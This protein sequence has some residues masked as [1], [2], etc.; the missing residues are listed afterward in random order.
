MA[1]RPKTRQRA[2]GELAN[3]IAKAIHI[4]AY[5]PGEWLRQIDLEEA[6]QATR[7][8]VRTALDELSVRKTIEHVPNRG[9]RVVEVDLATYRAIRDT[10]IILESA[11]S[12]LVIGRV[13]DDA[14]ARLD[15]LAHEFSQAVQ[16]G[17]RVEQ[18]EI[19]RA[20]HSLI[21]AHCGNPVLVETI[22]SLRDRSRG[23][24]VTVWASHQAL[25]ASDAD[26]HAMVAAIRAGDGERL[27]ELISQH[28]LKDLIEVSGAA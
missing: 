26:H 17:T 12:R 20:F 11:A 3:E 10:R 18:S 15:A 4:R 7:F 23:S 13:D 27:A 1:S 2:K 19:N 5:R 8:D 21:Y 9:Y 6:F 22:W 16:S 28:I 14:V 24:A 25:L